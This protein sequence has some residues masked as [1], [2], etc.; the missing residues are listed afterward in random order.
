MPG[1]KR[2]LRFPYCWPVVLLLCSFALQGSAQT[3]RFSRYWIRF[4][5]KNNS[6]YSTNHPE[7]FLSD[8]CIERRL[9]FNLGFDWYDLP[10][11]PA[12]VDSVLATGVVLIEKSKWLNSVVIETSDSLALLH[13]RHL[14]FV[15]SGSPMA[16]KVKSKKT[17]FYPVRQNLSFS[18]DPLDY[19]SAE[20]Q[21]AIL[22]GKSLH[23][24][25]FRGE[26]MQIAV[27]DEGF[28]NAD[29]LF[30]F[31]SL[32][33]GHQIL[34][35]YNFVDGGTDVFNSGAHGSECLSTM[36]ANAPGI[37][38]GTAPKA[39]Y[40]LLHTENHTSEYPLEEVNWVSGAEYADSV[41]ADVISC[42]LGYTTFDSAQFNNTYADMNGRTT[43]CSIGATLA[44]RKGMIVCNSAGNEGG[45]AWHYISA[46]ADA[47]SILTVGATD[48]D[49]NPAGFSSYG[50][51]ADGR[52]K[53]DV[54]AVG[55]GTIVA[56]PWNN[57]VGGGNGTSFSNPTVAGLTACLWQAHPDKTNMEIIRAIQ[58]C[59]SIHTN[60]DNHLGYG[61]PNF[62]LADMMLSGYSTQDF[63]SQDLPILFPNPFSENGFDL[64]IQLDGKEPV[65]LDIYDMVGRKVYADNIG[66][67][68]GLYRLHIVALASMPAGVYFVRLKNSGFSKL[69]K[70][71]NQH[72]YY[73]INY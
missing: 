4:T 30:V 54:C 10:V 50:P 32:N 62:E 57:T 13:I 48:F 68:A 25:G 64:L 18:N 67:S 47:D 58:Q 36:A 51:T 5:D 59:S 72:S 31:D 65:S 49:G 22:E 41:G 70:A 52:I 39:D 35:T 27:L 34:G 45:A 26:G 29:S 3:S 21:I 15:L 55:I 46:P 69:F 28:L 61:I 14:P 23:F 60:P 16:P 33:A 53:P 71:I 63:K 9:R 11:N 40:W 12:Y 73:Y 24:S 1:M 20:A 38:V 19:G 37:F 66:Y 42:S 7:D 2:D 44:A 43:P 6:P 56:N 8:R 17:N